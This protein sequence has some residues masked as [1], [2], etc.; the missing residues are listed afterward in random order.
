MNK[1]LAIALSLGFLSSA[2]LSG[3]ARA[4][5]ASQPQQQQPQMSPAQ[6][7]AFRAEMS[8]AANF[9]LPEDFM[10][11][12]AATMTAVRAANIQP[13]DSSSMTLD[14]TISAV[15]KIPGLMPILSQNGFTAHD[16]I[17]GL[18]AFGMAMSVVSPQGQV[19][20]GMPAPNPAN[21]ALLKAHPDQV[22]QLVQVLGG[23]Q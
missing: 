18:T 15:E 10:P 14:Q 23:G 9:R 5:D 17:I 3:V 12:M 1:T 2:A 7:A 20:Q 6:Q 19:P 21:V 13:P 16:F 4:Q 22:Q 8:Q 11:R